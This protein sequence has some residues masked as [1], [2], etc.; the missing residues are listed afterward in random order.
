MTKKK[1]EDKPKLIVV[2]STPED[3]ASITAL[4][5][6]I[7]GAENGGEPEVEPVTAENFDSKIREEIEKAEG[8]VELMG[9]DAGA[10]IRRRLPA[11]FSESLVLESKGLSI[12][13]AHM[14]TLQGK[15]FAVSRHQLNEAL[16]AVIKAANFEHHFA[17]LT[18]FLHA[19]DAIIETHERPGYLGFNI[20]FHYGARAPR[21]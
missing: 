13:I 8:P 12:S 11:E 20:K 16:N 3:E 5:D 21:R 14:D 2:A 4:M 17:G 1:S 18:V 7:D 6:S 10:I 15:V 9:F 19:L